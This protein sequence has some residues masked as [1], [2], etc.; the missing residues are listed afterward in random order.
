MKFAK[1]FSKIAAVILSITCLS[2]IVSCGPKKSPDTPTDLQI[3]MWKSGL[4]IDFMNKAIADFKEAYPQYNVNFE[5][6][7]AVGTFQNTIAQGA[8]VN[9]I[10]LY[11]FAAT[12]MSA[13]VLPFLEPLDSVL[14][15]T[16]N[17]ADRY[18][19]RQRMSE[20]MLD[21]FIAKDGEYYVLP[22]YDSYVGILDHTDI[23]DGINYKLPRTT[24]ELTLLVDELVDDGMKPFIHF[25]DFNGG[26]WN[27]PM[28]A[29]QIQYDGLDAYNEELAWGE[30][31][32]SNGNRYPTLERLKEKDGRYEAIKVMRD[33]IRA[34]TCV[35]SSNDSDFTGAQTRF[36]DKEAVMMA[37]GSWLENE[38]KNT[39]QG[40]TLGM[41]K[42]PVISSIVDKCDKI[43]DEIALQGIIDAID[44]VE[45]ITEEDM[46]KVPLTGATY[47]ASE[48][49]RERIFFARNIAVT[50]AT[51]NAVAIPNY[52]TAKEAAKDFL[53]FFYSDKNI[54]NYASINKMQLPVA[55]GDGSSD[56]DTTGWTDFNKEF[57]SY[58][59]SKF[60]VS[61]YTLDMSRIYTISNV[62]M[63]AN[64][65]FVRTF[66]NLAGDNTTPDMI[67]TQISDAFD[68]GYNNYVSDAAL[69]APVNNA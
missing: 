45:G 31:E 3:H 18:T 50:A 15:S 52:S 28:H 64:N 53:R 54:D 13:D 36:L 66:A 24:M 16:S 41:M 32:D 7:P 35:D 47:E 19:I 22:Y 17:A 29:W 14:D 34:E 63:F 62:N 10:D 2:G 5:F 46:L 21:N 33:L 44:A 57:L 58:R 55:Y 61:R 20:S 42:M 1:R 43:K 9:S 30:N 38:M 68:A 8:D 69:G 27:S 25:A 67:W 6:N 65:L 49:D 4:G 59:E 48:A 23:I 56:V 60:A 26:Y 51:D 40:A 11:F 12:D 39:N 37:N